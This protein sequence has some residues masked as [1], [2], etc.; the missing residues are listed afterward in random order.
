MSNINEVVEVVKEL[1]TEKSI[2]KNVRSV[3][4][5]IQE[6][7]LDNHKE[8][9]VKVNSASQMIENISLDP[10][11]SSFARTQIWELSSILEDLIDNN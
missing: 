3:L 6:L 1:C 8:L 2:P 5:E 4:E 10:N 11:I 7:L 9:A